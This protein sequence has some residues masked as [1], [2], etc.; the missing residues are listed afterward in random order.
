MNRPE[1]ATTRYQSYGKLRWVHCSTSAPS[2]PDV[3]LRLIMT[4]SRT[5]D[6]DTFLSTVDLD[7]IAAL[8]SDTAEVGDHLIRR[9]HPQWVPFLLPVDDVPSD[10]DLCVQVSSDE[11]RDPDHD[12]FV[13]RESDEDDEYGHGLYAN[14]P[15]PATPNLALRPSHAD[16]AHWW[17]CWIGWLWP[18]CEE[19]DGLV[20]VSDSVAHGYAVANYVEVDTNHGWWFFES[21]DASEKQRDRTVHLYNVEDVLLSTPDVVELARMLPGTSSR[22]VGRRWV[23]GDHGTRGGRKRRFGR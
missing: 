15:H 3:V 9:I 23:T 12:R 11:L 2:N 20:H 7:Q 16:H 8:R 6:V 14:T 13:S 5:G 18:G 21:R 4:E 19:D 1:N 17:A 22:R 10:T